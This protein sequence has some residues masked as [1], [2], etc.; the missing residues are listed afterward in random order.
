MSKKL[1][2]LLFIVAAF[3]TFG[4]N[5][6]K[7]DN[8][9]P[10]INSISPSAKT[11][12]GLSFTLTVNGAGFISSSVVNFNASP[13]TTTYVSSTRLTATITSTDITAVGN[14][15]ITVT[16]PG[17]G[18]GTSN[19]KTLTVTP[20]FLT[21][22]IMFISPSLVFAGGTSFTLTVNGTNFFNYISTVKI[23]G[24]SRTTTYVSSTTLTA[25]IT[26]ADIALGGLSNITVFNNIIFGGTSNNSVLTVNNPIPTTTS[27]LPTSKTNGD[28]VPFALTV[29]GSNFVASSVIYI[30]GLAVST[31]YISSSQLTTTI[32]ALPP[33]GI[34]LIT[35]VNP[36]PGGGTSNSQTLTIYN[37]PPTA[38]NL[39]VSSNVCPVLE[40]TGL[41]T[42][43]WTYND[44]DN[45]NEKKF[46][47]QIDNNSDFSSPAVDDFSD[48]LNNV[49]PTQ[50][51]QAVFITVGG[52]GIDSLLYNTTYYWRV[53]VWEVPPV[54]PYQSDNSGW[55]CPGQSGECPGTPYITINHPGPYADFSYSA[56][57]PSVL[58]NNN[59]F[60]YG[61]GGA[62]TYLWDFGDG[63]ESTTENPTHPY[64]EADSYSVI[65]TVSDNDGFECAK[66]QDITTV[67]N[68]FSFG[69]V[70]WKEFSSFL[71][72]SFITCGNG[73]LEPPE[74]CD[75]GNLTNGD[76]CS[77]A[78]LPEMPPPPP[79]P[80]LSHCSDLA[81]NDGDS[82]ID[83]FDPGCS[84][85]ADLSE[86]SECADMVDNDSD[87][88]VDTIDPQCTGPSDN[89]EAF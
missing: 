10:V 61:Q 25:T 1:L 15:P 66:T 57:S 4:A 40:N 67:S 36:L 55:V 50:N 85:P 64:P 27:I 6:V 48:N 17:P 43:S 44:I 49:P 59:S 11:A 14:Y 81:D 77:S 19:A 20:G 73:F 24:S 35:V 79:P 71:F 46:Q 33:P 51:Q 84:A 63:T 38:N 22:T 53:M 41:A 56:T 47:I 13:R 28:P 9:I 16:S 37:A 54:S 5:E 52:T 60:C 88:F 29:N 3:L 42:F 69:K 34:H 30:N 58:F 21:P 87:T 70:F 82:L 75:D 32:A 26:T 8:P 74:L 83:M 31:V 23:N 18:G 89:S 80:P 45:N 62:C 72:D 65:L 78:C 76:G 2:F 86:I 68:N 39:S 12:G 7:A